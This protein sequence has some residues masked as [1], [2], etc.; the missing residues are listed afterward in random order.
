[1]TFKVAADCV[2]LLTDAV[3]GGSVT[4]MLTLA[5][6]LVLPVVVSMTL[7]EKESLPAK[8]VCGI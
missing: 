5:E 2:V 3:G 4:V 1:M 7:N 8:L 6:E